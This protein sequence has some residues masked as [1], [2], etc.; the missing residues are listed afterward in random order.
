[1]LNDHTVPHQEENYPSLN[2]SQAEAKKLWPTG[3]NCREVDQN[4]V[5]PRVK[6]NVKQNVC[7]GIAVG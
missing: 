7:W 4:T 6:T 2:L 5:G 1:M 3:L